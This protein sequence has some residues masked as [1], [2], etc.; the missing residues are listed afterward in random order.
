MIVDLD[1]FDGNVNVF[2]TI[3][4]NKNKKVRIATKS[5]RLP[6][7]I[8]RAYQST[9]QCSGLMC[10]SVSEARFL[11]LDNEFSYLFHDFLVAYPTINYKDVL[12]AVAVAA[13]GKTIHLMVDCEE[14]IR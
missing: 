5:I 3:A 11:A 9:P 13:H 8:A 4:I 10:Y 14:H 7:L 12:D 1:L 6:A 2:N